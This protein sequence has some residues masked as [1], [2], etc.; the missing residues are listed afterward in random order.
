MSGWPL[1]I[2]LIGESAPPRQFCEAAPAA[3]RPP[4]AKKGSEKPKPLFDVAGEG[5][6]QPEDIPPSIITEV[7]I[8]SYLSPSCLFL[9][10]SIGQT[11]GMEENPYKAPESLPSIQSVSIWRAVLAG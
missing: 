3:P 7:W 5:P 8:V 1:A 4:V 2:P 10:R 6:I 11:I 9:T